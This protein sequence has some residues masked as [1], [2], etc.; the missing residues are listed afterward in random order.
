MYMYMGWGGVGFPNFT[1]IFGA[2]DI[3]HD[4]AKNRCKIWG[5]GGGHCIIIFYILY[6]FLYLN[7]FSGSP[8]IFLVNFSQ[9]YRFKKKRYI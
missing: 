7:F 3:Q 6:V 8:A 5:G 1:S 9:P 2:H 4:C